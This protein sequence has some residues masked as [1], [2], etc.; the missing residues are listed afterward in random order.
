MTTT[1]RETNPAAIANHLPDP[2]SIDE[3]DLLP[4]K[5]KLPDA[6]VA[7]GPEACEDWFWEMCLANQDWPWAI[8]LNANGALELMPT[9]AF[10]ERREFR[11]SFTLEVWNVGAGSAGMTTGP[12]AAYYLDNHAIRG[13]DAA[14][15]PNEQV[16]PALTE[17]PRTWPFCP[18]FVA[19]VRSDAPV[20]INHL[21]AKMQ[22]YMDNGARLA[23][24][25]DPLERTVRV[26][27]AGVHEPELLQDPETLEGGDVLS[28]FIFEVRHLIFDLK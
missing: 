14:W 15:T 3:I 20:S 10:G 8:E 4:V 16:L 2:S 22:E 9:Y 18:D 23:W 1:A 11:L 25:I 21:L 17:P 27:R 26:Y 24:L 7:S 12:S 5:L 6:V 13:P 19:E 28:G